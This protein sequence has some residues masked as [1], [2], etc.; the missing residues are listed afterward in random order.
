MG[1]FFLRFWLIS[2]YEFVVDFKKKFFVLFEE[3]LYIK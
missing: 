2:K 3:C 1:F